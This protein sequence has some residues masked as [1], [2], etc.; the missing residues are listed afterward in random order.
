MFMIE[1]GVKECVMFSH[2]CVFCLWAELSLV[3][4]KG[5]DGGG[6]DSGKC[7]GLRLCCAAFTTDFL[8]HFFVFPPLCICDSE[9]PT[10]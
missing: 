2:M 5:G 8:Y 10:L 7:M 6:G 3:Y 1:Q 9:C 4:K